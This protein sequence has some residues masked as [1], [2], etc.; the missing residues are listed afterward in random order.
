M[1]TVCRHRGVNSDE[2][3]SCSSRK[4]STIPV[5]DSINAEVN[6][7]AG[8]PLFPHEDSKWLLHYRAWVRLNTWI[9]RLRVWGLGFPPSDSGQS[10]IKKG[11]GYRVFACCSLRKNGAHTLLVD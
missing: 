1:H 7:L 9:E 3:Y 5:K 8:S 11:L 2:E 10:G 4:A 6:V